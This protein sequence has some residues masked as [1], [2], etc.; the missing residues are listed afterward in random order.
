MAVLALT[1]DIRDMR[2]RLGR[3]VI[4]NSKSGEPITCDDLGV[5]GAMTVLCML[6]GR[7]PSV[8]VNTILY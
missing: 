8:C 7:F 5:G 4:G 6:L 1:S 2:E 3:M